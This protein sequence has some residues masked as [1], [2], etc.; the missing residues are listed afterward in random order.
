MDLQEST[1]RPLRGF[2]STTER[3]ASRRESETASSFASLSPSWLRRVFNDSVMSQ[4][5]IETSATTLITEEERKS[6][7]AQCLLSQYKICASGVV[8][9]AGY[10]VLARSA[11]RPIGPWPMLAGGFVGTLG[12]FAYGYFVECAHLTKTNKEE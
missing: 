3:L 5:S 10:S 2:R 1:Y 12:D 11:S 7:L 6:Q 4:P 9:G 8:T